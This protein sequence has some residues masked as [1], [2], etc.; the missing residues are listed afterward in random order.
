MDPTSSYTNPPTVKL[1][2]NDSGNI[3]ITY[4]TIPTDR[5]Y[6]I[7]DTTYNVHWCSTCITEGGCSSANVDGSKTHI[8]WC[9]GASLPNHLS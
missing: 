5:D 8:C 2:L 7:L 4:P 9:C 3:V 6:T 1:S